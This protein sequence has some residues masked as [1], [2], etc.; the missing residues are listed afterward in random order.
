MRIFAL[1]IVI[2]AIS[3]DAHARLDRLF[4]S[5]G[6]R[7]S[8]DIARAR[9]ARPAGTDY[10]A[11]TLEGLVRRSDG[12]STIWINGRPYAATDLQALRAAKLPPADEISHV[13]ITQSQ[14]PDASSRQSRTPHNVRKP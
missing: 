7:E 10:S 5:K 12:K 9:A 11:P 4:F 6:E 13:R 2:A 14:L 3:P 8:M 1:A